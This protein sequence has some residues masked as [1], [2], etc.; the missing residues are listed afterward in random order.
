MHV[1]HLAHAARAF[2]GKGNY[3]A[4]ADPGSGSANLPGSALQHL[5]GTYGE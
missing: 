3:M 4:L 5:H 1:R 2:K